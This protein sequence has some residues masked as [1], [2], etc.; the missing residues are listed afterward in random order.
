MLVDGV[1]GVVIAPRGRLFRVLRFTIANGRIA[2]IDVV[3][4]PATL[5]RIDL[6]VLE[7]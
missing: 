6:G 1:V 7:P 3:G 2:R 4:D 5:G